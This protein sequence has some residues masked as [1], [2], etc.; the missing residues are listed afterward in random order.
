[1]KEYELFSFNY[2]FLKINLP[3][4]WAFQTDGKDIR[5]GL[6]YKPDKS[7]SDTGS[8]R[9]TSLIAFMRVNSHLVPEDGVYTC[10]LPGFCK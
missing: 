2:F 4:S 1:M 6:F 5:Y 9:E 7:D 8:R 10:K 3:Y